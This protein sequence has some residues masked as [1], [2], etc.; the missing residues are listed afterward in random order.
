MAEKPNKKTDKAMMPSPY[1]QEPFSISQKRPS[2][3]AIKESQAMI[4][5]V[6]GTMYDSLLFS[7]YR[8]P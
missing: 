7:L 4:L 6:A 2:I 1:I 3:P 5:I 8:L